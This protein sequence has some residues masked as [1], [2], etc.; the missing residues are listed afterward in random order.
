MVINTMLV[1]VIL[2]FLLFVIL[3]GIRGFFKSVFRL[4]AGVLAILLAYLIAPILSGLIINST[5]VDDY[6]KNAVEKKIESAVEAELRKKVTAELT[7]SLGISES[8]IDPTVIDTSVAVLM[9]VELNRNQ[10]MEMINSIKAPEFIK[11]GLIE[12]NN[13]SVKK[14]MGVN[15]FYEYVATYISYTVVNA[16]SYA[17]SYVVMTIILFAI[18]IAITAAVHLPIVST[19]NIVGG[20]AFGAGEALLVV[21][22]FFAI[23]SLAAGTDSGNVMYQQIM[24]NNLLKLINDK[25]IFNNMV[26]NISKLL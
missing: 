5:S 21:W 22:I 12:N 9:E 18:S 19:I 23:I 11:K 25:N 13:D 7:E 1:I 26:M 4:L 3:G 2:I 10:Q 8:Q 16:L 24:D 6:I 15:G 20:M 17:L 14:S